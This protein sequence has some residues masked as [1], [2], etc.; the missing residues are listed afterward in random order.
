V[1][2]KIT[3]TSTIEVLSKLACSLGPIAI[4]TEWH[5]FGSINRNAASS[6]DIDLMIFCHFDRQADELRKAID[7]D[8]FELPLHI[9]LFTFE[10]ANSINV[11]SIQNS[12]SLFTVDSIGRCKLDNV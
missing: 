10:E 8:A 7:C 3:R 2:R 5:L 9:S 12:T 4:N 11:A 1:A 6:S